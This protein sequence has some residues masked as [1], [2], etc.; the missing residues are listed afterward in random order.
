MKKL[1]LLI[2]LLV[3]QYAMAQPASFDIATYTVPKGW[4]PEMKDFAASYI[5]TNNVT[6]SWCRVTIYKSIQSSGTSLTDF[7]NE[8]NVLIVKNAWGSATPPQPETETEE[9]WTSHSAAGTFTFEEKEA[10][11][12][13]STIS[14]YGVELSIVVLMNSN[15]YWKE[16]EQLLLSLKLKKPEQ[17]VQQ[18]LP[19]QP[20]TQSTSQN[21]FTVTNTPG[22]TGILT[23][24]TNF[25]DGWVAQPFAD[26]VRVTK[27]QFTVLLHY[28]IEI[29]DEMRSTN[30]LEAVLFD[31]LILPRYSVSNIRKFDNNGP[32]YFC[33]YFFE[34]DGVEKAT[35]KKYHLGLRI[36]TNNGISKCIEIISPSQAAFQQ[37]FPNQ[38]KVEALLNYNKFAITL[39][40][41]AGDWTSSS[42]AYVNMYSTATGNY[43][44][45]NA[46]SSSDEFTFNTDGTYKSKHQGAYGMVGSM[47]FYT[48]NYNGALT[49]SPCEIIMTKRFDGKTSAFWAQYEAVRGGRILHLTDKQYSG[50]SFHLGRKN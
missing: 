30:Q 11:S 2:G 19:T 4:T 36:I 26:Y 1:L 24:T 38:E 33:I 6:K 5:K 10:Y 44:G 28:G 15:E 22:N 25:D 29:T 20:V 34:A 43:A 21:G 40:D 3:G 23:A 7:N 27:N 31:R 37:E 32:C 48:Q 35:G 42:G 46:S 9:G 49:V 45:M 17:T 47:N 8:W 12:L 50:S 16:V 39:T 41:L 18:T 13:L 14:G